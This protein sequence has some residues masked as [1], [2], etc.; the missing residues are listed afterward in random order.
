LFAKDNGLADIFEIA[1]QARDWLVSNGRVVLEIGHRQGAAVSAELTSL[2]YGDIEI[3]T[4]LAGRDRIAT[5]IF[6]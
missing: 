5:A 2:G 3:R 1:S 4:D 6:R